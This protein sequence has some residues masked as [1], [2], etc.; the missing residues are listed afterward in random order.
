[1]ATTIIPAVIA[2]PKAAG[3]RLPRAIELPGTSLQNPEIASNLAAGSR[4]LLLVVLM[5]R[6]ESLFIWDWL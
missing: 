1:M 6:L 5:K 2:E 3:H 4:G